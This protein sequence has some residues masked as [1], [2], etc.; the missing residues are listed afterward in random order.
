VHTVRS[1]EQIGFDLASA[2]ETHE[3]A[4]LFLGE[5]GAAMAEVERSTVDLAGQELLELCS[6]HG[7]KAC[8]P[9]LF[10][11]IHGLVQQ[12]LAVG[13]PETKPLWPGC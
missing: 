12:P 8:S 11:N 7:N 9:T 10:G 4:P 1:D 3:D 2:V 13:P 5:T 6:V